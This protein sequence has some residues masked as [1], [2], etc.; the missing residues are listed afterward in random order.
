M[1][2][3]HESLASLVLQLKHEF[4]ESFAINAGRQ[5]ASGYPLLVV[6]VGADRLAVPLAEIASVAPCPKLTVVPSRTPE[7]LGIAGLRG[8]LIPVFSLALLTGYPRDPEAPRWLLLCGAERLGLAFTRVQGQCSVMP[9]AM[10]PVASGPPRQRHV[11]HLVDL[12]HGWCPVLS[13][14]SIL[15]E[16]AERDPRESRS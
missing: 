11:S 15:R 8:E 2:V 12:E 10:S 13:I 14:A 7:L 3:D 9:D 6:R 4:D 16:L 1:N 5:P